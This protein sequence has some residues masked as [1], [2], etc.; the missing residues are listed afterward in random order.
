MND[1]P[2]F[3]SRFHACDSL[4]D[5]YD[6][7]PFSRD[8]EAV[9]YLADSSPVVNIGFDF[10]F[11]V[12]HEIDDAARGFHA[13]FRHLRELQFEIRMLTDSNFEFKSFPYLVAGVA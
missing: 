3:E 4:V 10:S 6:R 2:V 11:A 8:A 1:I 12:G 5:E 9:E 13:D 7:R